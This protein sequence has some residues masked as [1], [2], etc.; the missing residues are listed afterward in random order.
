ML[1]VRILVI[2]LLASMFFIAC[3]APKDLQWN[4]SMPA[5]K[6]FYTGQELYERGYNKDAL[7]VFK[8]ILNKFPDDL[9]HCA[10]SQYEIGNIHYDDEAWDA[11]L[12]A[13]EEVVTYE[14]LAI[15][16]DR[17][18]LP[19]VMQPIRLARLLINKIENDEQHRNSTYSEMDVEYLD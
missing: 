15:E 18:I 10:W 19:K 3:G 8:I 7:E 14:Q 1:Q 17:T 16:K 13:F 6:L 11:A 2:M 12:E 9:Y 4:T 5:N